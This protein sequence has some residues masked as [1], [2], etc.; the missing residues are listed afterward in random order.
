MSNTSGWVRDKRGTGA[1][2]GLAW[3]L[4]PLLLGG[5]QAVTERWC[6]TAD[7][8]HLSPE[9]DERPAT[10]GLLDYALMVDAMDDLTREAERNRLQDA[11]SAPVCTNDHVRLALVT[12]A[13]ES[14]QS[15]SDE[16]LAGLAACTDH[17]ADAPVRAALASILHDAHLQ[18]ASSRTRIA[19]LEQQLGE[20]RTRN[21]DLEEQLEALK[22]I[23]RSIIERDQD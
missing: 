9:S 12:R 7:Y 14:G 6:E 20:Q 23:E 10:D 19:E 22:S 15:L 17:T 4:L 5:C 18:R 8:C 3:L 16:A 13:S 21:Q 11:V 2:R 1:R